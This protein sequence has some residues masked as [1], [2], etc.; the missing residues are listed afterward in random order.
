MLHGTIYYTINS[1]LLTLWQ[2]F[3]EGS[4]LFRHHVAPMYKARSMKKCFLSQPKPHPTTLGWTG[5]LTVNLVLSPNIRSNPCSQV[6]KPVFPVVL[7]FH[8][9]FSV[10]SHP[11]NSHR[12][13]HNTTVKLSTYSWLSIKMTFS[14][15]KLLANVTF[16]IWQPPLSAFSGM[17]IIT[18][19]N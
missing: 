19:T 14:P 7:W 15:V 5:T 18:K 12:T 13:N 11:F 2:Q 16:Y 10:Y 4:F 3:V 8:W 17:V 6:W 1:A 9:D